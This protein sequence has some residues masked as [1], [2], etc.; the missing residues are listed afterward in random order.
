MLPS[1]GLN[2]AQ[3]RAN[4]GRDPSPSV[5][6]GG[7][8][9]V[10]NDGTFS[11]P[12]ILTSH[13]ASPDGQKVWPTMRLYRGVAS[14]LSSHCVSRAGDHHEMIHRMRPP[15]ESPSGALISR[16]GTKRYTTWTAAAR[17][18]RDV[19]TAAPCSQPASNTYISAPDIYTYNTFTTVSLVFSLLVYLIAPSHWLVWSDPSFR[20]LICPVPRPRLSRASCGS[21]SDYHLL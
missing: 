7:W 19:L 15:C 8:P 3:L 13:P 10:R 18:I 14:E 1:W 17:A 21:C 11:C 6:V 9:R 5:D 16:H 4:R 12:D 20:K 2:A